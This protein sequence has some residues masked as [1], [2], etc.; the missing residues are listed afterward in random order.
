MYGGFSL[1]TVCGYEQAPKVLNRSWRM[2]LLL[3][4]PSDHVPH[5]F[6][7]VHIRPTN[8]SKKHFYM[9]FFHNGSY[10]L[11]NVSTSVFLLVQMTVRHRIYGIMADHS[12]KSINR[13]TIYVF[14]IRTNGVHILYTISFL[15]ENAMLLCMWGI[16]AQRRF[17]CCWHPPPPAQTLIH[18]KINV[19]PF[20]ISVPACYTIV[21]SSSLLLQRRSR[22]CK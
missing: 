7:R 3:K 22:L 10:Y 19:P 9:V 5:I 6:D 11:C 14:H 2:Q 21:L 13:R 4:L 18:R 20:I 15:S 12:I 1:H 17:M 8:K 16:C